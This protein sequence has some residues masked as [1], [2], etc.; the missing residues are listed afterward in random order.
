MIRLIYLRFIYK[1]VFTSAN[2]VIQYF[3]K[4][5]LVL[6]ASMSMLS[7]EFETCCSLG[8]AH[9]LHKLLEKQNLYFA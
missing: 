7:V 1:F 5:K 2:T 9:L 3:R 6:F 4:K 8:E